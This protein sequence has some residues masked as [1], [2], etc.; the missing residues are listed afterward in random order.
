MDG[1]PPFGP[2]KQSSAYVF[3]RSV[4][5]TGRSWYRKVS[6]IRMNRT[7]PRPPSRSQCKPKTTP[8]RQ[9]IIAP[10]SPLS[11]SCP[12]QYF[13]LPHVSLPKTKHDHHNTPKS[14]TSHVKELQKRHQHRRHHASHRNTHISPPNTTLPTAPTSPLTPARLCSS[15]SLMTP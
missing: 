4:G 2:L 6:W 15:N 9:N 13:L 10:R 11:F 7:T 1:K 12:A 5:R 14:T 8:K 3:L